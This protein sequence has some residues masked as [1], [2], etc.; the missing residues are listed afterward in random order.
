LT[1]PSTGQAPPVGDL[2]D[3][4]FADA[5]KPG[6]FGKYQ[7]ARVVAV[8]IVGTLY[9]W[10]IGIGAVPDRF[11][12]NSG[13]DAYY[14]LSQHATVLGDKGVDGYYDLLAR[15]FV[16]GQ[17]RL[18]VEPSPQLLALSD[19]WSDQINRPYR[20]LDTVLYHRHYYLYHG[21][22]PAVLLFGPW[23][24][25]TKHDFPENFATFLFSLG[26]YL[27]LS[28]LFARI[29]SYLSIR[30]PLGLYVLFL[31]ALGVG[32]SVP[33]LLERAAVYEVAISCA[34]FCLC[35]GF[36]F[37]FRLLAGSKRPRLW[38][39]LSGLSFGL[40]IGCRPHLALAAGAVFVVLVLLPDPLT[41]GVRRL[42]RRDV[43]AFAI[44]VMLCGAAVA[45]Y[46]YARFDNPLEFG[47]RYLLGADGYRNFH[48]STNLARGLYY[49]L[50][51][52]PDLVPEFP[53]VRLALRPPFAPWNDVF[54]SD[55]F[56]E[57]IAGLLSLCPLILIAPA[58][59]AWSKWKR[60]RAVFGIL[61]AMFVASAASILAIASVPFSSHRYEVDFAPY[62]LLIA[63]VAAGAGL[64][65]LRSRTVH[66]IA[67][68]GVVMLLL[69]CI[70]TNVAL[71]IQGPYDQFVQIHP[72][73]YV[74]LARWFSPIERF[75]PLLNPV[76]RV[77]GVFQFNTPCTSP[78]EP[79]LSLGE[80]GSRY[81]LSAECTQDGHIHLISETSV[82]H[83][84]VRFVE[85]P[86]AAPGRYGVEL[87]F[88][89]DTKVMTVAWNGRIVL[90]HPLRFLVTAPSQIYFGEDPT[91]GNRV[92][93][94]G[95]IQSS[96][97]QLFEATSGK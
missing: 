75:R 55:Y 90:E 15:A 8:L 51:S 32:Q 68:A 80:F 77:H 96:P 24:L 53:F 13:L 2:P 65:T 23:Y 36:Y 40:A 38:G 29:L 49:L 70:T 64:Q 72:R 7:A 26:G 31:L 62:L 3:Y 69:Y 60:D 5:K 73:T 4:S 79:L 20:L 1:Q 81:L 54:P 11:T 34:Y 27:F 43:L 9:F 89:P 42:F 37:L 45:I 86:F 87:E 28:A 63:C 50:I 92:T 56:L 83:P 21:A 47:I 35:S 52:P 46:N 18:P 17:L 44:P 6:I 19:P 61:A 93:F 78:K 58:L 12:W 97:P 95:R 71:A 66:R 39:A 33:F 25:I 76:S 91:L 41:K 88:N 22:T 10:L 67:T 48:L 16:N 82:R 30:L 57:P 85:L 94:S 74:E 59:V 84:D 14:G